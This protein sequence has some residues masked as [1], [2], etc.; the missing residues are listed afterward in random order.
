[1]PESMLKQISDVGAFFH[2]IAHAEVVAKSK[3]PIA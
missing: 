2:K 3:T 1:M